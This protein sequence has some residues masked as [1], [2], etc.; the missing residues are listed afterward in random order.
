MVRPAH[1]QLVRAAEPGM[2]RSIGMTIVQLMWME[3]L[4]PW[5]LPGSRQPLG[6]SGEPQETSADS[7]RERVIQRHLHTIGAKLRAGESL[8]RL[9]QF[10]Q[11][12]AEYR[13]R[14]VSEAGQEATADQTSKRLL[15]DLASGLRHLRNQQASIAGPESSESETSHVDADD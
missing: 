12:C 7:G 1:E 15:G 3:V 10:K 14:A 13:R 4:D 9:Q 2:E 8:R 6:E 5:E 11:R